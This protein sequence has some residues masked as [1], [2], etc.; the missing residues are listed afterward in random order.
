MATISGSL[1]SANAVMPGSGGSLYGLR[2]TNGRTPNYAS[3]SGVSTTNPALSQFVGLV[4]PVAV[5][6]NVEHYTGYATAGLYF[7]NTGVITNYVG[8]TVLSWMLYG[9]GTQFQYYITVTS[10]DSGFSS[11][12]LNSW[13]SSCQVIQP[14]SGG[15]I[16]QASGTWAAKET[17]SGEQVAS[18]NW[19]LESDYT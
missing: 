15:N 3:Y 17:Q 16:R 12:T 10:S 4:Y 1:S 8:G 7:N 18:G 19:N 13:V 9:S 11:G 5:G 6:G 2:R 14:G